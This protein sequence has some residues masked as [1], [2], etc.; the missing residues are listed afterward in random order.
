M[1]PHLPCPHTFHSPTPVLPSPATR[2]TA[3]A[4]WHLHLHPLLPHPHT[5]IAEFCDRL[6]KMCLSLSTHSLSMAGVAPK[7]SSEG[8]K[9]GRYCC[10][11]PVRRTCKHK[12]GE[13]GRGEGGEGGRIATVATCQCN[14]HLHRGPSTG[15]EGEEGRYWCLTPCAPTPPPPPTHTP[16]P[17][18]THLAALLL[19]PLVSGL[20]LH[21]IHVAV[22]AAQE[23][24]TRGAAGS[25]GGTGADSLG[26]K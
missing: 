24:A 25:T 12:G 10:R 5:C 16:H 8:R 13:R 11:P 23:D 4:S 17:T 15:S 7:P 22:A 3:C 2:C 26:C 19:P 9:E 20:V 18:H 14:G 1:P 21:L 6:Y